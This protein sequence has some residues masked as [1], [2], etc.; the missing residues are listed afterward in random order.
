[1]KAR[2]FVTCFAAVMATLPAQAHEFEDDLAELAEAELLKRLSSSELTEAVRAQNVANADIMAAVIEGLEQAWRAQ[3]YMDNHGLNA[4]QSA[5]TYDYWQSDEARWQQTHRVGAGAKLSGDVEFEEST[6]T[7]QIQLRVARAD[8]TTNAVIGA[9]TL[10][11]DVVA[12]AQSAAK[13]N[14]G[15]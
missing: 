15:G 2:L 10:G 13:A 4:A 5:V 6:Q 8:P 7:H 1:M 14:W 11:A 12:F 9:A 3:A